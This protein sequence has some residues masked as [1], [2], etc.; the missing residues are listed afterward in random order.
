MTNN[1]KFSESCFRYIITVTFNSKI[2]GLIKTYFT[3]N[4]GEI[5]STCTIWSAKKFFSKKEAKEV[6]TACKATWPEAT[7]TICKVYM[8]APV[9]ED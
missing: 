3:S 6:L 1:I 5:H 9:E 4:D 8:S 7:Y 2:D